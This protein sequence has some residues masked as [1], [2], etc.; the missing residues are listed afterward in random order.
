M[1]GLNREGEAGFGIGGTTN[2]K[3][4]LRG[5][6]EFMCSRNFLNYFNTYK[7]YDRNLQFT[8]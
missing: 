8:K 3:G 6:M 1:G 5:Q 2:T 7:I 4:H